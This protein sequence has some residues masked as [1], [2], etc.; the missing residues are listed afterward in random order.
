MNSNRKGTF[1]DLNALF[2]FGAATVLVIHILGFFIQTQ[3]EYP[4]NTDIE[5]V[6]LILLRFGRSLFI[7]ATGMLL[8][9]WY[10]KR[11]VD[12]GAFWRKRWRVIVLPYIIWTAIYTVFKLQTVNVAQLAPQF[13]HSLLTGSS[14]YHLY[15]IPLYLQLNLLFFVCKEWFERYLRFWMVA[16]LFFLQ[17]ALYVAF[18]Y[19]FA[20]P[21]WA[22]DWSAGPLLSLIEHGYVSGQ[23][24]VYMYFFTFALGAY[25]GLHVDKWRLW[26][27]RIK[28]P[29]WILTISLGIW[30][31]Y[32]YL[33]N[34][35]SYEQSLNIFDPI[36]LIYTTS[37]LVSFYPLSRYLGKLP[38]LS[39]WLS[40]WARYNMA[41]YLVHPL[42]LFLLESYV[43][44]RL[45]WSTPVLMAAMFVI[46]PPLC[47]FLYEHTLI[48]FWNQRPKRKSRR[49]VQINTHGA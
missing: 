34:H 32:R 15:Y 38:A 36:Y 21:Q 30:I 45:N 14:F 7:F 44:F 43:I 3:S 37:F 48:S 20:D 13:F 16:L 4:W 28:L 24:Y 11:Q 12:W 10:Q 2:V 5:A 46:T 17:N 35:I 33:N 19:L 8:F 40:K 42:I 29:A 47:I 22:I 23:N 6:L 1:Q 39:E 18:H 27:D 25:A 41:I 49:R 26:T 9:Y 31:A